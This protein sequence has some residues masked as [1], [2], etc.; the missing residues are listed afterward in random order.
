LLNA[1]QAMPRGGRVRL[2]GRNVEL[3]AVGDVPLPSGRYVLLRVTDEGEGIDPAHLPRIFDPYFS[4]KSAGSGLGLATAHSIVTRHGGYL[5]VAS[6]LGRGATFSVYLPACSDAR[7]EPAPVRSPVEPAHVGPA[8]V[9][10]MDDE[11]NLL[12][13][14]AAV[15][16]AQG[17]TVDLAVDGA[18]AVEAYASALAAGARYDLVLLDLTVPG[19]LGGVGALAELRRLDPGVR[20]VVSSGYSDDPVLADYRAHGFVGRVVKPFTADELERAVQAALAGR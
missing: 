12:R 5:G 13:L 14:V 4:T 11:R 19:G 1:V 17:M 7:P 3:G 9:L 20:A 6:E 16:Q 15:L 10:V 18:E 2:E 8:R